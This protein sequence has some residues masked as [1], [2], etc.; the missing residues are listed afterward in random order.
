[1]GRRSRQL[2]ASALM[3]V[4]IMLLVMAGILAGY[5]LSRVAA[6]RNDRNE[7]DTRLAVVAAALDRF[8]AANGY[9]PCPADPGANTGV[10]E[11]KPLALK[12]CQHADDGTVPW[13][14]LGLVADAG[15][16]AWG[17][18]ISY[19]VYTGPRTG[20]NIGKGSLTQPRGV[21]MVECDITD[22]TAGDV[23]A[24]GLCV[25]TADVYQRSTTRD[26]FLAGKG[27]PMN[28]FGTA[29]ADAAYVLIS[30]GGTGLGAWTVAGT[31]MDMPAGNERDNTKED[32]QFWIQAFSDPDTSYKA[33]AH[34]DDQLVYVTI[35]DLVKRIGLAA[36]EWPEVGQVG[37]SKGNIQTAAD[38][39]IDA[40]GDTG[41]KTINFADA[42]VQISGFSGITPTNISY[43]ANAGAGGGTGGIGIVGGGSALSSP[44]ERLRADFGS[45]RRK[46]AIALDN[47][48][49]VTSGPTTYVEKVE[50]HFYDS[51]GMPVG[52]TIMLSGCRADGGLTSFADIDPGAAF[53]SVEIVPVAAIGTPSG[54][55]E[56][57]LLVSEINGCS[58]S[59]TAICT[60]HW[61]NPCP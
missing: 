33:A 12:K 38:T 58:S 22:P 39:I 36:R 4:V 34:F 21:N 16:D 53:L 27:L 52:S 11:P 55:L 42:Q 14:V 9:L 6:G 57:S 25:T 43:D 44:D 31:Q 45:P 1:M 7:T 56:S 47:F 8:A 60:T 5:A 29:H 2:G 20:P 51:G 24:D 3:I 61:S 49:T 37:F 54:S 32:T 41:K 46:F 19:R 23:D 59:S 17:R 15:L 26:A 18:K 48:G 10:P 50:L 40:T 28:D 35:P 30:H 13:S